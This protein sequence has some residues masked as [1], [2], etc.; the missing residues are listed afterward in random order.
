MNLPFHE[1]E[2]KNE[3]LQQQNNYLI[4]EVMFLKER[5]HRYKKQIKK[6]KSVKNWAISIEDPSNI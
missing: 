3:I 4:S 2:Y 1:Q 6:V 5:E